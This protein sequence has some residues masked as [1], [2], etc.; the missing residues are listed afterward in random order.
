ML[1]KSGAVNFII[2]CGP[3][4]A[5]RV[6]DAAQRVGLLAARHSYVVLTLDLHTQ[7]LEPFSHGGANITS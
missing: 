2:W 5:V 6:L 3:E 7:D 4:C 1:K